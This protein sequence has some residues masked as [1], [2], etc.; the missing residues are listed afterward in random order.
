MKIFKPFLLI[1]YLFSFLSCNTN[2]FNI[3]LDDKETI[4]LNSDYNQWL[5]TEYGYDTWKPKKKDFRIVNIVMNKAIKNN[6]F[7]FIKQPIN[8]NIETYYRQYIPYINKN[9]E[10]LIKINAFCELLKIPPTPSQKDIGF[11]NIDWK[12]E[13]VEVDG[14]E[15]CYWE[16]IINIDTKAYE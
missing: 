7:Y 6:K 5:K 12:N 11:T 1:F 4:L 8:K 14:G 10:R 15:S 16:L 13:Y 9:N 2:E 3:Q